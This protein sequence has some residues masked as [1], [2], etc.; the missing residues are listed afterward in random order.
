MTPDD[1]DALFAAERWLKEG[2]RVALGT[3]VNTWGSAPRPAGSQIV[4]R[5][6]GAFVGSVS[7][8][9]VEGA[10]IEA[11]RAA[12]GDGRVRHL[13][14]GVQDVQAWSVGLACGGRIEIFVE[15]VAGDAARRALT[16]LNNARRADRSMARALD[17]K[18]GEARLIDPSTDTSDLGRAAAAAT[19]ADRSTSVDVEGR[20]WFLAVSNP[21]VDLMIV[22][23]VHVA[24]SL[25]TMAMLL[26]LH[27]RII[28]PRSS[29]ATAERF[30]GFCLTPEWPDE[31][32]ARVPL[33]H[34]SAVVTLSHD[35]KID[36]PALAIALRSPAFYIGALGSK[37]THAARLSRLRDQ[38]F[39]DAVLARVHGPVGLA[40]G[41][42]TPEEIAVSI[43][44]Q[45][46]ERLRA[47]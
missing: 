30:P 22:G 33:G 31:A 13:E 4:V 7:G 45:I 41:A 16:A 14:F 24:Q 9:C 36:D 19:H 21:P 15:P 2:R 10:V 34:R 46:I 27:V 17:L 1:T 37:R 38:G 18:T 6:D 32:L 44:A 11:A 23:A 12:I 3:V 42:K 26:G 25:A 8:G 5:D 35:P 43:L 47:G 29:F 20:S 28:D 40:I 39:D